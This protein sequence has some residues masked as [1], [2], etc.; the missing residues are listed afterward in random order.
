MTQWLDYNNTFTAQTKYSSWLSNS[1]AN[2]GK[3]TTRKI[4]LCLAGK[5]S[6]ILQNENLLAPGEAQTHANIILTYTRF[7]N[8]KFELRLGRAA[9]AVDSS[10][11]TPTSPG[12]RSTDMQSAYTSQE[13]AATLVYTVSL[14]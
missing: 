10:T 3:I 11:A 4:I 9:V 7:C 8:C 13:N 2:R 5:K 1:R 6:N 12:L 14:N